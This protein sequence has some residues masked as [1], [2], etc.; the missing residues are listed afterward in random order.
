MS[1]HDSYVRTTPFELAFPDPQMARELWASIEEEAGTREVDLRDRQGFV[2]L[3]SV[4]AFLRRLQ[5]PDAP[6]ESIHQYGA[7]VYHAYHFA[8]NGHRLHLLSTALC[9]ALALPEGTYAVPESPGEVGYVQ[10]PR[11][12]FWVRPAPDAPAEPV[13]GF[14]CTLSAGGV[15][16]VLLAVGMR[17]D[18]PGLA[19]VPVPEAPWTDAPS[20]VD[21]QVRESAP[22]FES[23]LPGGEL[24]EL[25]SFE[26]AGEVL[27]FV[28]RFLSYLA[29]SPEAAVDHEPAS[30]GSDGPRPSIHPFARVDLHA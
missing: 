13:D 1:F 6:S 9:R 21:S 24:E 10:L 20:W 28:A 17:D 22:D 16:Q 11:H 23:T 3:G 4:G 7:L 27:K 14:F 29:S 15:M 25:Y 30:A 5:G 8:R 18:R 2:M 26:I 12:L 19:V